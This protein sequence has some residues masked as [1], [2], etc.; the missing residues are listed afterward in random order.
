MWNATGNMLDFDAHVATARKWLRQ[1]R[2]HG[3]LSTLAHA[4]NA[5]GWTELLRGRGSAVERWVAEGAEVAAATGAPSLAS[6]ESINRLAMLVWVGRDEEARQLAD[7]VMAAATARE[8]GH[9]VSV[10]HFSLTTL[11]LSLCRYDE[12]RVH[13]LAVFEQDPLYLGT[14][15][16]GDA[17]EAAVRC[18]DAEWARAALGRLAERAEAGGAPW[19]LGLLARARALLS[20]DREAE[21]L[22]ER[23]LEQLTRSGVAT[24]LARSRLLYG[25][26]LR[27][28]RRR[29][30]ARVQ[31]RA[32]HELFLAMDAEAWARRAAVEL[33]ATGE[34]ARARV[35]ATRDQLTPQEQQ[36]AQLAADGESNAEIGAQL[37]ISPHTVAYHLRKVFGKLDV[38]SRTQLASALPAGA[39]SDTRRV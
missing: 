1:A 21:A 32:A 3:A 22:Y 26:W 35:S 18:G 31:L 13:A 19:G 28:R 33:G 7:V 37:F 9:A 38:T 4:V 23:S 25:E 17:V 24:E 8:Q 6:T 30:D 20:G 16:L 15:A 12:A 11:E 14:M 29:R 34:H 36:V 2:T 39:P 5:V 27:R 10:A